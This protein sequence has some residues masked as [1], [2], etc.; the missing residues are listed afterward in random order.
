MLAR[1]L[2]VRVAIAVASFVVVS[3][4]LVIGFAAL[5][6]AVDWEL[7]EVQELHGPAEVFDRDGN[8]IARFRAEVDRQPVALDAISTQVKNAVIA[9]E[10]HRFYEHEGVDALAVL[11]AVWRNVTTGG[12]A[13]GGSTLTQQYVKNAYVGS[14]RTFY[15]KIREAVISLQLEKERSKNGILEAYLNRVYFGDGA[16]GVEAAARTYFGKSAGELN[17]AEGATLASVLGAPSRFS[18]RTDPDT[19]KVRR[20]MVLDLMAR[21]EFLDEPTAEA[22][23]ALPLEIVPRQPSVEDHPHFVEEVRRQVLDAYGPE[24]VYNGGLAVTTTIDGAQ[25]AA[26][27]EAVRPHLPED[28]AF[29]AG[30]A[31][32]HPETGDVLATWS[33][34]DFEASQV[35]LALR[36]GRPSGSTFKAFVL[37][38]ALEEGRSLSSAYPA[39]ASTTI[40][41]WTARG[42]GCGG[43]CTLHQAISAS[44][45]TV[46]AQVGRD[47]GAADFTGMATR[48]GVRSTLRDDD[49]T[50][51]LGTSSV[52]PLDMASAFGTFA[53]GGVA[54]PARVILE[55]RD[56]EGTRL[57]AP[58]PR[59]PKRAMRE[60]WAERFDELGYTF[61][62]EDLGRCHR[63]L[64]SSIARDVTHGLETAVAS[65]TGR[66]AKI[67]RP[68][69][70]K[71]GT[72]NDN[73]EV[74]FAGYTPDLSLAVFF[75]ARD[76]NRRLVGIRG[77][78]SACYGG[79]LPARIW[80]DAAAAL[81][82]DV[83]PR[84]FPDPI[85]DV[86]ANPTDRR[87]LGPASDPA[88]TT[89]PE[90]EPAPEAPP[91]HEPEPLPEPEPAPE[92]APEPEQPDDDGGSGGED[93]GGG[94]GGGLPPILPPRP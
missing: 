7:P 51:A 24:V 81:L 18:P 52:T 43:R 30:V 40:G 55:V 84:P 13:E 92:P 56:H 9:K 27:E 36:A 39:P 75:G 34:R 48:L 5:A 66:N 10:D 65:G 38:T 32:V 44:I 78:R 11:R 74:W 91:V 58:D 50:Q 70:G 4:G 14:D 17:A 49:L 22:H 60:A 69:A 90:P 37:A 94:G 19:A 25:Q 28:T 35:D 53:N 3:G 64:A 33:G 82:A 83:E 80:A 23:K 26:L 59:Q 87:E 2:P 85:D 62:E 68:Q 57:K 93:G 21:Y 88:P 54:C 72:T 12:I 46:F 45:N 67:G 86:V 79:D 77:C 31:A 6:M 15:R 1:R 41:G 63:V 73:R 47:V 71:T 42:G 8:L 16:Y 20:D 29:D 76:D 89:Q 61:A